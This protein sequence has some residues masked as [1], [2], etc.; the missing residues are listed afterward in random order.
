MSHTGSDGSKPWDRQS[1]YG[2]WL[3]SSGE[4]LASGVNDGSGYVYS[5]YIDDAVSGRGHRK[6]IVNSKFKKTGMAYCAHAGNTGMLVIAY[7]GGFVE[8]G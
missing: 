3:G 7:A 6:S 1:K 8:K 4:N 5:L 2:E